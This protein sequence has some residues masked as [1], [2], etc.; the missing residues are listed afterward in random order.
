M[1]TID[2]VRITL[3]GIAMG[4]GAMEQGEL[5]E[6]IREGV[7]KINSPKTTIVQRARAAKRLRILAREI[8]NG[9]EDGLLQYDPQA[10]EAA[11]DL[12]TVM[13][14]LQP[15]EILR[16]EPEWTPEGDLLLTF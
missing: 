10:R 16:R 6:L 4:R 15:L 9:L 14:A 5:C 7:K 2:D 12:C 13:A 11:A 1:K 8:Q 3:L